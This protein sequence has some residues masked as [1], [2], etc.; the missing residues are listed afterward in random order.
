VKRVT[1]AWRA[2]CRR[3]GL[4]DLHFHDLRREFAS[5]LLESGASNHAVRDWLGHTNLTTTNRYLSTC[6]VH[7]LQARA[8]FE[9]RHHA[10][11]AS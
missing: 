4:E 5:R 9:Q 3:A 11:V 1:T 2:A 7:L 6:R 10:A 8:L